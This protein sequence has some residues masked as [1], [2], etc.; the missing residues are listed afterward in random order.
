MHWWNAHW[1][2]QLKDCYNQRSEQ[3]YHVWAQ[4]VGNSCTC[5]EHTWKKRYVTWHWHNK[6]SDVEH[7]SDGCSD[8]DEQWDTE[9]SDDH[10][11]I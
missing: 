1:A 11:T 5:T 7:W 9:Y 4:G 10:C 2:E 3:N 6:C 8:V